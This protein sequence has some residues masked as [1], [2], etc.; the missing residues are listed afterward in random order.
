MNKNKFK[1]FVAE[2]GLT[3]KEVA[4]KMNMN[5]STISRK[6]NGIS[7]FTRDEIL[8]YQKIVDISDEELMSVFF[9]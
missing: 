8:Q 1:Y 5:Q 6:L 2:K 3:I 7:D 9:R 4:E